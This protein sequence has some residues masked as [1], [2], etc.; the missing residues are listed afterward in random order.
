MEFVD[1]KEYCYDSFFDLNSLT[2]DVPEWIGSDKPTLLGFDSENT[3]YPNYET[4]NSAPHF[5]AEQGP[6]FK[7]F[8]G[9]TI[10]NSEQR[11]PT[12]TP[13]EK[14]INNYYN[15]N[16]YYHVNNNY[17]TYNY[18]GSFNPN[19]DRPAHKKKNTQKNNETEKKKKVTAEKAKADSEFSG[20]PAKKEPTPVSKSPVL[21]AMLSCVK[22]ERGALFIEEK[23]KI[24]VNNLSDLFVCMDER[25]SKENPTTDWY[26]RLKS[27]KRHF[28]GFSDTPFENKYEL[29]PINIK[30]YKEISDKVYKVSKKY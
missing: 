23:Q 16:N 11:T 10:E 6:D 3:Y 4:I 22:D 30:L 2:G 24:S 25:C 21:W 13:S 7:K 19:A 20:K 1:E 8:K 27:V 9:P 26:N 17:N 12:K 15:Y 5:E 14:I 29:T 28:S 18:N